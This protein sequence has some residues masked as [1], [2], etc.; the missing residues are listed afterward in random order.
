MSNTDGQDSTTN[1]Q[2]SARSK[3]STVLKFI[4]GLIIFIIVT[5]A[6]I[7]IGFV[8]ANINAKPDVAG[9]I[10]PP[11][12][13]QI[14]DS[15][16]N[17]IANIHATEN[18]MPVKIEQIPKYLQ[19][20]F[21]AIE[22]N[23]FYEHNGIDPRG[24]ARAA[25][26]NIMSNEIAEGGSTITQQLAKN[27]YLTQDRTFKRKIQEVFLALQLEKQY[28]KQEILEMYLNQIYF[29]R[30]AYGVQAAAKTYFNK[31][32]EEL[33]LSE[34][35]LLA[36]IPKSPN[37]YSPFN[38]LQA[39]KERRNLVL[40]QMAK[41]HYI[42]NAEASTASVAELVLAQA[43]RPEEQKDAEPFITFVTQVLIEKYGADAIYKDGL[44]IYTTIDLD[45][46][47]MAQAALLENLPNDY[48]DAN[49]VQQPQGAIVAID[50]KTGYVKAMVG[51]R[52]TDQFNRAAQAE[53]QP[54]SAFKPFVFAAALENGFTPDTIIE[55][56]PINI[57]G[58]QPQNDSG[59]FS[60]SVPMRTVATYSMNV[61]T[62]RIAQTLGMET[63]IY[64]AQQ[65][66][67]TTF[68]MDGDTNDRNYA[69]SLGGMTRG[70]TPL[71]IASAYCT[72]V[73]GGV[74]I[75]YVVVTKVLD[76]NGNVLEEAHPEGIAVIRPESAADLTNMLENVVTKGTGRAAQIGRPAAGKTGT[77][78][79]YKDAWFVGYTPDLVAA[80]WVGNDDSTSTEGI[81]GGQTPA[82]TWAA[83]MSRALENVPVHDFDQLVIDRRTPVAPPPQ[84]QERR[85]NYEEDTYEQPEPR[86]RSDYEEPTYTPPVVEPEPSYNNEP[87]YND[88]PTRNERDYHYDEPTYNERDYHYDEPTY[89]ERDYNYEE[90]TYNERDYHYNEPTYNERDYYDEPTYNDSSY[91]DSEPSYNDSS[92]SDYDDTPSPG[93]DVSKGR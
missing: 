39:A 2:N 67:I 87:S 10:R 79:D 63:V 19:Q 1:N 42:S 3:I 34:C 73:N 26:A 70:V 4:L 77:T 75:P 31:N 37:Y 46:Q 47:R 21:I 68:V 58:W 53:R 91:N 11:A 83:F 51:G 59:R 44:K 62:V 89:N 36:G 16:G 49:G 61:P 92:Y 9:E 50:P 24:L 5:A 14:Y 84:R 32:V 86:Y 15:A 88:E 30:G 60:G 29:G 48:V 18:R 20:A 65:M 25:Y 72:F 6:G 33:D 85:H 41:Y 66:G 22:D 23:R 69:T 52:G 8:T 54:G 82:I 7:A 35:A 90:P 57:G 81:M 17:E 74:H 56:K 76:R 45:M 78:S 38:D 12:S 40:G 64:Y 55:D 80:V 43:D 28:T 71:E 93:D 13:S 27:A